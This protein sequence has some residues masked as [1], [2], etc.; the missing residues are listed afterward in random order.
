[1][2]VVQSLQAAAYP[3]RPHAKM[4]ADQT[5]ARSITIKPSTIQPPPLHASFG[6]RAVAHSSQNG[7]ENHKTSRSLFDGITERLQL[8]VFSQFRTENRFPLF[9]ELL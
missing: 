4:A 8:F 5:L 9:L 2:L 3:F 1:L 7:R 6:W